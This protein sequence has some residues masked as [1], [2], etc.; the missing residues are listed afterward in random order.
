MSSDSMSVLLWVEGAQPVLPYGAVPAGWDL[1]PL[2]AISTTQPQR[3]P[4]K[5]FLLCTLLSHSVLKQPLRPPYFRHISS[6]YEPLP[7]YGS[8]N[9]FHVHSSFVLFYFTTSGI[10]S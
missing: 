1:Q 5:H 6:F 7:L 3:L 4:Y 8:F 2:D 10:L 9:L